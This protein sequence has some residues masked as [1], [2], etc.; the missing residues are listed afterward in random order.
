MKK[1]F[2]LFIVM[3]V[4]CFALSVWIQANYSLMFNR[5]GSLGNMAF[6]VTK[7]V[8]PTKVGE[9]IAFDPPAN[10]YYSQS[11]VKII[12]GVAGD[13]INV[14]GDTHE[15]NGINL[16][17]LTKTKKGDPLYPGPVGLIPEG[18]YFVYGTHERSYDSRYQKIGLIPQEKV[19]G[20][21]FPIL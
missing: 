7:G 13:Q 19:I 15:V 6:W 18:Q 10:P 5:T 8:L 1:R 4:M 3:L 12:G 9:Y 20:R 17:V 14:K 16:T 21:A 2:S 11:F